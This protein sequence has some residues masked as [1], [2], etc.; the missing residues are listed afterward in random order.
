MSVLSAEARMANSLKK[1]ASDALSIHYRPVLLLASCVGQRKPRDVSDRARHRIPLD[2]SRGCKTRQ[3][4][5]GMADGSWLMRSHETI[6]VIKQCRTD[7]DVAAER[8]CS[9]CTMPN[10]GYNLRTS[11]LYSVNSDPPEINKTPTFTPSS[12]RRERYLTQD[13]LM[14]REH[15]SNPDKGF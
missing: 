12:S 11:S 1:V 2:H 13:V 15:V 9:E 7:R 4:Y 14:R 6:R 8:E 3:N 5:N 10:G